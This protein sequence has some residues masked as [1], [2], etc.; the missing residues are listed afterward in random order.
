MLIKASVSHLIIF[1]GIL[2]INMIVTYKIKTHLG[3]HQLDIY[4]SDQHVL[5]NGELIE[6]WDASLFV[7]T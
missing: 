1:R 4:K 5:A 3:Y 6:F 2:V 7:L